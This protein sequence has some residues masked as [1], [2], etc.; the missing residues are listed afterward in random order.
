MS[1]Q[2]QK[3][4]DSLNNTSGPILMKDMP[5]VSI[6]YRGLLAYSKEK[7]VEPVCLTKE[8]KDSFCFKK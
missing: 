6:D 5:S 4:K 7:G 1:G 2:M 3:Y 8:E